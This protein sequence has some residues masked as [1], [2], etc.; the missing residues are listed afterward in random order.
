[1]SGVL[2]RAIIQVAVVSSQYFLKAF[3]Q[4]YQIHV[5][6]MKM[7]GQAAKQAAAAQERATED[8]V[9]RTLT[10]GRMS[11]KEATMV[12]NLSKQGEEVKLGQID[13]QQMQEYAQ[14]MFEKNDPKHGGSLYLQSKF[15]EARE[16]IDDAAEELSKSGV[17]PT[18]SDAAK[19]A[20]AEARTPE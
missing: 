14:K 7:G 20:D 11:Y 16:V 13:L 17:D 2:M 1:M 19:H 18:A 8:V 5:A 4:A 6:R 10:G 12:L 3:T 9:R 15:K